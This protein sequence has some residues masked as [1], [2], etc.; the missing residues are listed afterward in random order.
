MFLR[1]SR[2]FDTDSRYNAII[3]SV[4]QLEPF[5]WCK[6]MTEC[7]YKDNLKEYSN[8]TADNVYLLLFLQS[9]V[10]INRQYPIL[11]VD[12]V[13][14]TLITD[15][16]PKTSH[17]RIPYSGCFID[18]QFSV[19][20]TSIIGIYVYDLSK[21]VKYQALKAEQAGDKQ[22]R[23]I[24]EAVKNNPFFYNHETQDSIYIS[25]FVSHK[26]NISCFS[27]PLAKIQ[28]RPKTVT[29]AEFDLIVTATDYAKNACNLIVN[30]VDI[31]RPTNP[32]KDVRIIPYYPD[33]Q[34][35]QNKEK[36]RMS[37]I[38]VF[39]DLKDYTQAYNKAKRN[40]HS[41]NMDAEL[42][43]G[44]WRHLRSERFT[45]KRGETIWIP[46]FVRGMDKELFQRII[47]LKA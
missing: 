33:Q 45:V 17:F 21:I 30:H 20:D 35:R 46:P 9:A 2:Q 41:V 42:V 44:H 7:M 8:I 22:V 1:I 4:N 31:D 27:F 40:R 15:T 25:F 12:S 16:K 29:C 18:K 10:Q 36:N 23:S 37:I 19:N 39:G 28:K 13:L 11:R 38:R 47:K 43:R 34:S 3:D 14:E 26:G 32:K 5:K 6:L 24:Y